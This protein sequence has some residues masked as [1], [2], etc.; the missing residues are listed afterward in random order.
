MRSYNQ[1]TVTFPRWAELLHKA[2]TEP[3]VISTAFSRFHSYSVRNQL[4][5]FFQCRERGI[6]PGPLATYPKWKDLGRY[7]RKGEKA[8][9]LCMPVTCKRSDAG[10]VQEGDE[11]QRPEAITCFVYCPHWFVLSQTEGREYVPEP[12]PGWDAVT[13]LKCLDVERVPFAMMDGNVQGYARHRQVA[14]N[15]VA[16]QPESTLFHEVAHIV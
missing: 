3:G 11:G 6:Q 16:D 10:E 15:P 9:T 8:L 5:A 1:S 7:V 4:L 13:A 2:V 14:I 12:L